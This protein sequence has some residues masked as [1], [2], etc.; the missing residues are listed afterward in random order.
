MP[1][2]P[3]IE[4]LSRPSPFN[5]ACEIHHEYNTFAPLQ[6]CQGWSSRPRL[7]PGLSNS[8]TPPYPCPSS[9]PHGPHAIPLPESPRRCHKHEL[10]FPATKPT[11]TALP[12]S[13]ALASS[14]LTHL[15]PGCCVLLS[16]DPGCPVPIS[17]PW[18]LLLCLECSSLV[19]AR[20]A[21]PPPSGLRSRATFPEML[22]LTTKLKWQTGHSATC[23]SP[24]PS[25]HAPTH[26]ESSF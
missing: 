13:P 2:S 6:G 26:L 15:Q 20:L 24:L 10:P 21:P 7:W 3:H 9:I 14:S 4:A 17:R 5:S 22:S 12:T 25:E 23:P 11:G 19:L 1:L 18:H 8:L 16:L